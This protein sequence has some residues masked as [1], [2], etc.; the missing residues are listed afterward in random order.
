MEWH[1]AVLGFHGRSASSNAGPGIAPERAAEAERI[2][3]FLDRGPYFPGTFKYP[4]VK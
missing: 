2:L 1:L 4:R 3:Q